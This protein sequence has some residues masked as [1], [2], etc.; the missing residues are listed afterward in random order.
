MF[1]EK[2]ITYALTGGGAAAAVRGAWV[3]WTWWVKYRDARENIHALEAKKE[4]LEEKQLAQ[5]LNNLIEYTPADYVQIMR[6]HNGGGRLRGNLPMYMSCM[7]EDVSTGSTRLK[8]RLQ[9]L[10]VD[11]DYAAALLQL[12]EVKDGSAAT[13]DIPFIFLTELYLIMEAQY[14][15]GVLL[16]N[17]ED[18]IYFL[19]MTSKSEALDTPD[20]SLHYRQA[21]SRLRQYY[22]K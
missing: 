21:I 22:R 12:L 6:V 1:L 2:L 10:D 11:E 5:I 20:Y 15:R 4:L 9:C 18:G 17:K 7:E 14:T 19:R 16:A 8:D 13:A 3:M